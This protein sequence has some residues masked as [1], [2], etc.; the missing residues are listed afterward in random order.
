MPILFLMWIGSLPTPHRLMW[1]FFQGHRHKT[2]FQYISLYPVIAL[3]FWSVSF[4]LNFYVEIYST[5]RVVKALDRS[6]SFEWFYQVGV[7]VFGSML[8]FFL[9]FVYY[10]YRFGESWGAAVIIAWM[11][12]IIALYYSFCKF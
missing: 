6:V 8:Y 10:S 7:L 3:K 11:L 2:N 9:H 4:P 5:L 1:Q 12:L